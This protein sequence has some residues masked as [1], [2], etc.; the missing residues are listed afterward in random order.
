MTTDSHVVN[1]LS[2]RNPIGYRVSF[3]EL[4][5]YVEEAVN[6]ALDD[7]SP[8]EAGGSTV[9]C[10]GIVVFGSQ[11]ISQLASTV[12][13]MLVFIAPLGVAI[14]LLAFIFSIV[15]YMIVV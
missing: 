13:A 1:T 11:R 9:W 3:E 4:Y 2:G 5:P 10:E 15:A 6:S 8:A 7:C 12:N 14:T